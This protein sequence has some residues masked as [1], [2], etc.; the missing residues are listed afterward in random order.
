MSIGDDLKEQIEFLKRQIDLKNKDLSQ[1]RY[2]LRQANQKMLQLYK[3]LEDDIHSL[4]VVQNLLMPS[5]LPHIPGFRFSTKIVQGQKSGGDY[6]DIFTQDK[7]FRFGFLVSS[8]SSY[9]LSSLFLSVLLQ[10]GQQFKDS[11]ISIKEVFKVL[12]ENLSSSLKTSDVLH[13]FYSHVNRKTLQVDYGLVGD[14]VVFY[15]NEDNIQILESEGLFQRGETL[16]ITTKSLPMKSQE[17]LLVCSPGLFSIPHHQTRELYSKER[18]ISI[19]KD[20]DKKEV[21][22]LRNDLFYDL[23]K[24]S[25]KEKFDRDVLVFILNVKSE[26]LYIAKSVKD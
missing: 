16:N 3:R 9:G 18:V 12:S 6:F 1:F 23:Q 22:D 19:V 13:L 5:E 20:W 21:H 15:I 26:T 11:K 8:C 10:W 2:N 25:Q 7:R 24:F 14:I 4:K 17:T